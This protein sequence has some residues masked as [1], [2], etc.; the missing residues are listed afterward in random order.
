MWTML[1]DKFGDLGVAVQL[2]LVQNALQAYP[3]MNVIWAVL[4]RLKRLSAP[5]LRPA[6]RTC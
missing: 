1:A 3:D 6:R 4:R 2:G 5:W